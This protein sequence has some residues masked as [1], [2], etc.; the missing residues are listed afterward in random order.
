MSILKLTASSEED[1]PRSTT[2]TTTATTTAALL[3]LAVSLPAVTAMFHD[4]FGVAA[5]VTLV[6]LSL[7]LVAA[8]G[9]L[10]ARTAARTGAAA[11]RARRDA[12]VLDALE[13]LTG[14]RR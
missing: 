10:V 5:S 13:P 12:D 1:A 14:A 6:V 9:A 2:A 4:R 3:P 11:A 8:A 7:V